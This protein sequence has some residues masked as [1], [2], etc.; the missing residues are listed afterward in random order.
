MTA[1]D[2]LKISGPED[3]LG[4]IPHSLGYWPANSLVA[5]TLQGNRL[6]ATLRVDLPPASRCRGGGPAAF[7]RTVRDYLVADEDADGSLLAV[8]EGAPGS[9]STDGIADEAGDAPDNDGGDRPDAAAL[10]RLL[11]ALDRTLG[12]AGLP[13]RDAWVVGERYWRNAFCTDPSCCT[14][15]G[16]PVE[17]IRNSLLN[18]EMVFRGSSIGAAPGTSVRAHPPADDPEELAAEDRWSREFSGR[19]RDRAQF[20]A[21]LDMWQRVLGGGAELSAIPPALPAGLAGYLR[22]TLCVA[23]WRDAVLVM[24]AAGRDAAE[25]GAEQF[26]MFDAG[27][28]RPVPAPDFT[29]FPEAMAAPRDA[30]AGAAAR[31]MDPPGYGD[32]LLG[33]QPRVPDWTRLAHLEGTLVRLG[34]SGGGEARAAALTARGWIE[35]CRGRGSFADALFAGAVAELPGYRLAELLAELGRRGT[36]CG[37]ARRKEAAWQKFDPDAA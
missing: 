1:P 23:A 2:H 30:P 32:V 14:P 9:T 25:A 33:L 29:G 27:P 10:D 26:G 3:I 17:D 8:F 5:M 24:A 20:G 16:R 4:F 19:W 21:V 28:G 22:A 6:G 11:R 15:P 12:R 18:A 37:W 36:L 34:N 31:R 7:A 13:V 35:W